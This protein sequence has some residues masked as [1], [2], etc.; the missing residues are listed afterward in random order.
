MIE[1]KSE[2]QEPQKDLGE[3]EQFVKNLLS[4]P[5]EEVDEVTRQDRKKKR[6]DRPDPLEKKKPNS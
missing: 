3:F 5:K 6:E 2:E 4:V 1:K